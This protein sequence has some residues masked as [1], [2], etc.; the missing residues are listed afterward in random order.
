MINLNYQDGN[1]ILFLCGKIFIF[2]KIGQFQCE[3]G[4]SSN[5][6]LIKKFIL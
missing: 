3:F 5:L 2:D 6:N 4:P 1:Y